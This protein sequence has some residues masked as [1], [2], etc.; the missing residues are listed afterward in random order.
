MRVNRMSESI[1][2]VTVRRIRY[3]PDRR[4]LERLGETYTF[5]RTGNGWKIATAMTHD[6]DSILC[7]GKD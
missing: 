3:G 2:L 6:P 7:K 1:A 5:R 4:E